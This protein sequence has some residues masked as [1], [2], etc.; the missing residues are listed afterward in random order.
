MQEKQAQAM[1]QSE[2]RAESA[3]HHDRRAAKIE[4][5]IDSAIHRAAKEAEARENIRQKGRA[6]RIE[7]REKARVRAA[8]G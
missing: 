8:G 1:A 5:S 3:K 4:H 7:A 6:N 2:G